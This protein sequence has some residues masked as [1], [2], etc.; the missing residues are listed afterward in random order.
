[1]KI[2]FV[3]TSDSR[4]GAAR[5]VYE[6]A[7]RVRSEGHEVLLYVSEKTMKDTWIVE[8]KRSKWLKK[9]TY[10]LD[11]IPGFLLS[12]NRNIPFTLGLFGENIDP[13]VDDFKPDIINF[14]WVGKGFVSFQE[15]VKQ[16]SKKRTYLTMH[17]W[18]AFSGGYFFETEKIK[19]NKFLRVLSNWNLRRKAKILSNSK[20]KLNLIAPSNFLMGLTQKSPLARCLNVEVINNGID[21]DIFC[22]HD[23]NEVRKEFGLEPNKKYIL[24]GS[25]NLK[26]DEAK[27]FDL[28]QS[29]IEQQKGWF[30]KKAVGLLAFGS[31]NPF[32]REP[33]LSLN[34][35][36]H[37]YGY[38]DDR[39]VLSRLYSSADLLL[40]TSKMEN[41]PL[42]LL[43]CICSGTPVLAFGVGGVPEIIDQQEKGLVIEPF[44]LEKFGNSIQTV[45]KDHRKMVKPSVDVKQMAIAYI[46]LFLSDKTG[47]C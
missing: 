24:F 25:V 4:G 29:A 19:T 22:H 33:F 27:G 16:S 23:K 2:L 46:N 37:Y 45:I 36:K 21:T 11:F 39:S 28:L 42:T 31:E 8:S 18:N 34:L 9:S 1:M 40:F 35:E 20:N 26:N 17:D 47:I 38:F 10:I 30:E 14:H 7:K 6:L 5:L 41:Y 12:L 15:I 43:E 3:S 32:Q 44:D 13:I